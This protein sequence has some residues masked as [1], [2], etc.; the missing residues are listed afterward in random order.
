MIE[1][2]YIIDTMNIT[3]NHTVF[4]YIEYLIIAGKK[5]KD[6]FKHFNDMVGKIRLAILLSRWMRSMT[7]LK[8]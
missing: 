7:S 1:K 5:A 8:T 3:N 2:D 6:W 4:L